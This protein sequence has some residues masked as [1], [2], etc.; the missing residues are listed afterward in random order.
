MHESAKTSQRVTD[1]VEDEEQACRRCPA[2]CDHDCNVDTQQSHT[3]VSHSH[4]TITTKQ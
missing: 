1:F 2:L 4:I 3:T